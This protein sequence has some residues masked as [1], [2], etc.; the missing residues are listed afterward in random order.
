SMLLRK[1]PTG[2][3]P[4][5]VASACDCARIPQAARPPVQA[6]ARAL[7]GSES[8]GQHCGWTVRTA[9]IGPTFGMTAPTG[10]RPPAQ[11]CRL[12]DEP[13]DGRT[14][15]YSIPAGLHRRVPPHKK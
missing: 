9:P 8:H 13:G 2:A 7:I 11:G 3:M 1:G 10:P 14:H 6:I 15:I 4:T 5:A 12:G